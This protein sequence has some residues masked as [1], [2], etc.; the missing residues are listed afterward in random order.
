MKNKLF[1]YFCA[2]MALF[3][4]LSLLLPAFSAG[5]D[6]QIRREKENSNRPEAVFTNPTA[7]TIN[8][9]VDDGVPA[10]PPANP[11]PST[12]NVSGLTGTI[13][14]TPGSIKVTINGFTHTFPDDISMVLV[15]PTGAALLIQGGAGSGVD[16]NNLTYSISDAGASQLPES[17]ALSTGTFKPAGYYT[18]DDFP[19]PGPGTNYGHPGPAGGGTATFASVF[20][21]TSPN[22]DWKLFVA[23]FVPGDIG[24]ISGGWTLEITTDGGGT[25]QVFDNRLDYFG[26]GFSDWAIVY[27]SEG[28]LFWHIAR[29][30]NPTPLNG[31]ILLAPFGLS[32][33]DHP[34]AFGDYN[35]DGTADITVWREGASGGQSFYWTLPSGNGQPPGGAGPATSFAWGRTGDIPS[36]E[37]D[38]DGDNK[39]DYTVIRVENGLYRWFIF[40]SGTNTFTTFVFGNQ[41]TQTSDFNDFVLPGADYTGDGM[42]DPAVARVQDDGR[43]FWVIGTTTGAFINKIQWGNF[44]TDYI[45]PAGD[46]DGDGKADLAVWRGVGSS[47]AVNG[48]WLIRK[49][50]GG[51]T[52]IPFGIPAPYLGDDNEPNPNRDLA[53][54]SGDYDGDKKTDIA[55]WRRSNG[56][57]Y[58]LRS[59]D[60]Q[61][62]S[63][64][65]GCPNAACLPVA[66]LNVF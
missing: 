56:T 62:M 23:D 13:P 52:I 38:Y 29:N 24:S 46:Y 54:R 12:I 10:N 7:I 63:Q 26:N 5:V 30:D 6:G 1:R 8:D 20:G 33:S 61:L 47:P 27:A 51:V 2:R 48:E 53:L 17:G 55:V 15:G 11:Y 22:G 45:V 32:A 3:A 64:H 59:S 9:G 21:G 28:R 43:I 35:G 57:F 58:V 42:D 49:S 16:A 66:S 18:G 25:P 37:G 41:G 50:S 14:S 19:P 44:S 34:A 60:G 36:R 4:A 31:R 39:M 65:W 40:R